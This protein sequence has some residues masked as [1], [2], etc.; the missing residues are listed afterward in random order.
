MKKPPLVVY[1]IFLF[2]GRIIFPQ[3]DIT[4]QDKQYRCDISIKERNLNESSLGRNKEEAFINASALL[5]E[6]MGEKPTQMVKRNVERIPFEELKNEGFDLI[7][8]KKK[9]SIKDL[10]DFRNVFVKFQDK[11][12]KEMKK[13]PY[14]IVK[15]KDMIRN[16]NLIT[17]FLTKK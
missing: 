11:N 12:M 9:L 15:K 3:I 14:Q 6:R 2:D 17:Y 5:W 4:K 10:L 8:F 7:T 1:E 16:G 13:R